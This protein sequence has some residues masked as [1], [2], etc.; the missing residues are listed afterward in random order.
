M[1]IY[2]KPAKRMIDLQAHNNR[3]KRDPETNE[4]IGFDCQDLTR[5]RSLVLSPKILVHLNAELLDSQ[6]ES[7]FA[8]LPVVVKQ[9]FTFALNLFEV[10]IVDPTFEKVLEVCDKFQRYHFCTNAELQFQ[11][12]YGPRS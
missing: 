4:I 1:I 8:K 3:A 6:V 7:V 9:K 12:M 11:E 5:N 2:H 10:E